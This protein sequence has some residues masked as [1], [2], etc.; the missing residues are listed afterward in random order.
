MADQDT[1]QADWD[2]VTAEREG[3][4]PETTPTPAPETLQEEPK[5]E[6]TEAV[7]PEPKP[8]EPSSLSAEE[9]NQLNQLLKE[10]PSLVNEL[11]ATKGRVGAL[12]S[13]LAKR[14][15]QAERVADAKARVAAAASDVAAADVATSTS[16]SASDNAVE[17]APLYSW[18]GSATT[19]S[20]RPWSR[21]W[22]PRPVSWSDQ[23][24]STTSCGWRGA[25]QGW[26]PKPA[27]ST[28]V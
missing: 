18:N 7:A 20:R 27:R 17:N 15:A 26:R 4:A 14:Q 24:S 19:R 21:W 28:L 2:A 8:E 25:M 5:A 6:T 10:F 23:A 1:S 3:A 16:W 9:R 11:K 22:A 12:Q 13:E